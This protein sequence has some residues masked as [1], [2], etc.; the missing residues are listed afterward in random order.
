MAGRA[1]VTGA[2]GFVGSTLSEFLEERG[3]SVVRGVQNQ[4]ENGVTCDITDPTQIH[5]LFDQAGDVT[6]V[7]HLA[8]I[9]FVP[10]ANQ[11]PIAAMNVNLQGTIH[12]ANVMKDR[13]S[14]ARML[15][16]SSADAYGPP[17]A[18]PIAESHP[19]N[20]ANA[21]A[22]SK[23]AADQFCAYL[24]R[25]EGADIVRLRPFNHSGPRQA[26]E[27]FLPSCAKQIAEIELGLRP[28]VIKV[29]NLLA[30]RDFTHVDD[31]VRAFELAALEGH[32][33]EA[34]NVC[35]GKAFTMYDALEALLKRSQVSIATESDPAR[36]RPADVPSVL[37]SHA[38]LR[39]ETGW[40]PCRSFDTLLDDL[41]GYWRRRIALE[42][43]GK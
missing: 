23:A 28:P 9:A 34:Y 4:L 32:G 35:S 6:H 30:S 24:S 1:I 41:L 7:F 13:A 12:L 42:L 36:M 38:K 31:V 29:G 2:G 20:P 37:G 25:A 10:A 39:A 18:L 17:L 26:P 15:Y 5:D 11:N 33:G 27:F 22:V 40:E 43:G 21:Y 16:I 14:K 3:W 19:L 8:A